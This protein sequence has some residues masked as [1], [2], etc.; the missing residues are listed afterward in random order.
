M[1]DGDWR[2]RPKR[3]YRGSRFGRL[4]VLEYLTGSRWSCRCDCGNS[5]T[6]ATRHLT[7][8]HTTSCG[9]YGPV[10]RQTHGHASGGTRSPEYGTWCAM[11]A[12]CTCP[13]NARYDRYGGRGISV[14]ARWRDSFE[15]FL[16]DMGAR[17]S[18]AHSIDR[19]DNDG[20]Y[21][22]ENCRWATPKQQAHRGV[23]H[24]AAIVTRADVRKMRSRYAT[25]QVTQQA[26]ADRYGISRTQVG[27]I[28]RGDSWSHV[29]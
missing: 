3:D 6:V 21:K 9:C 13:T 7:N 11:V 8:G 29:D 5:T 24:H 20:D 2:R 1:P 12:R 19:I 27:Y 28:V 16:A 10:S 15:A 26:L 23:A 18:P 14:C 17:P 25:R 22:P 4:V